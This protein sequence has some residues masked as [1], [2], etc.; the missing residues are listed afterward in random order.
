MK[1]RKDFLVERQRQCGLWKGLATEDVCVPSESAGMGRVGWIGWQVPVEGTTDFREVAR[2]GAA[3]KTGLK[4][5]AI[6]LVSG[7]L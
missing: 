4:V 1:G 3:A 2:Q 7:S 5:M 6:K